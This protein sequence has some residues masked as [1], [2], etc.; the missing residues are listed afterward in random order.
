MKHHEWVVAAGDSGRLD[1]YLAERLDLSRNRVHQLLTEGL[2][3][4]DGHI[5]RKSHSVE[6]GQRIVVDLPDP[7]PIAAEPE[8]IP[9][10]VVY[11]DEHLAVVD[12][13][14]GLVTHPA[15]GH[16]TGTLVNA[17]LHHL[18]DLSGIGGALRP[19]IVHRPGQGHFRAD[20]GGQVR[21]RPPGPIGR[22]EGAGRGTSLSH[23]P[24]GTPQGR[25]DR[26]RR[27]RSEGTPATGSA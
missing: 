3:Q 25:R 24:L 13:P 15:P 9:L 19:G 5:P 20:G 12:K 22:P 6:E 17:L 21:R 14:A 11:E 4:I 26:G 18:G 7:A 1:R 16:P 10:D 8:P 2:V 27:P 23:G